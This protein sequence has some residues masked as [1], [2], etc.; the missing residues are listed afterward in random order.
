MPGFGVQSL[1]GEFTTAELLEGGADRCRAVSERAPA[2][3]T[4]NLAICRQREN[5]IQPTAMAAINSAIDE[6]NNGFLKTDFDACCGLAIM[7]IRL[8]WAE[9]KHAS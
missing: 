5:R 1:N 7:G 8:P 9:A 3:L 6:Y 2:G 4:I